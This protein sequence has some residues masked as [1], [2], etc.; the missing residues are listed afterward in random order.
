MICEIIIKDYMEDQ[1][2]LD[3]PEEEKKQPVPSPKTRKRKF[4]DISTGGNVKNG[5]V[6][7]D[8]YSGSADGSRPAGLGER[9]HQTVQAAAPEPGRRADS[10]PGGRAAADAR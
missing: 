5:S 1:D 4:A 3:G 6:D 2:Q 8:L 9:Q 10:A 7:H